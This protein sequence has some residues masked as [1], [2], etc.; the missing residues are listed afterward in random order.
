M[1]DTIDLMRDFVDA[2][3]PAKISLTR[4]QC[5][6]VVALVDDLNKR[7]DVWREADAGRPTH[8]AKVLREQ[9]TGIPIPEAFISNFDVHRQ[10]PLFLCNPTVVTGLTTGLEAHGYETAVEKVVDGFL[11]RWQLP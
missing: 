8:L 7:L 5:R 4:R 2:G 11:V 9:I 1:S 10:Q 6:E 3:I